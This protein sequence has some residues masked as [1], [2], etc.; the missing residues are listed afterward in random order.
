MTEYNLAIQAYVVKPEIV[1]RTLNR[2]LKVNVVKLEIV[3]RTL[4]YI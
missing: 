1:P 2:V 4:N 3:P